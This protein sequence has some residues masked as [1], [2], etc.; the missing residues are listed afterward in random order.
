MRILYVAA[1]DLSLPNGQSVH[2]RRLADAFQD[3][4]HEL[5]LVSLRSPGLS[6]P[7]PAAGWI[8]VD[9]PRVARLGHL[10]AEWRVA[11]QA[12]RVAAGAPPDVCLFRAGYLSLAPLL[13]RGLAAR[14]PLVVECNARPDVIARHAGE[15][16][17]RLAIAELLEHRILRRA[18]AV[19][20][21]TPAVAQS[22][23]ADHRLDPARVRVIPNGA[24]IP[25]KPDTAGVDPRAARGVAACDFLVGFTGNLNAVQDLESVIGGISL[26]RER[27]VQVKLWI[28]G[29]GP[30]RSSLERLVRQL[31]LPDRV[32]FLGGLGETEATRV[33]QACQV[34]VAPYRPKPYADLGGGGDAM[35]ALQAL[36]CD[37]P[38]LAT[39][40]AGMEALTA[41]MEEPAEGREARAERVDA[42]EQAPPIDLVEAAAPAWAEAL[43]RWR[44]RWVEAGSPARNWPWIEHSGAG[45]AY[46][47][48]ART[49][50][51]SAQAWVKLLGDV[52]AE[53][54]GRING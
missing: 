14:V 12:E 33:A 54:A 30:A 47:R 22:L 32:D 4:G 43:E 49:W 24:W 10:L 17:W 48:A 41:A 40:V 26:L 37:R 11:R 31:E 21:V 52:C 35:K 8:Q 20:A 5:R 28:A 2:V 27:G 7:G 15:P 44:G 34:L 9:R 36:A 25:P 3:L 53:A 42:T 1:A 38:L 39:R 50:R 16:R 13:F 6:W 29:D 23:I 46:I 51:Q 18:R 45:I 19:G